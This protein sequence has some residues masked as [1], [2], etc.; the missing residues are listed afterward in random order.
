MAFGP[1]ATIKRYVIF[2]D[3]D[4]FRYRGHESIELETQE[5]LRLDAKGVKVTSVKANGS[6]VQFAQDDEGVTVRTGRFSGT[7]EVD[8][9]GEAAEKLVGIY[10]APYEGGYVISTQFES[11][12]AREMFPC[13]DNPAYKAR[14]KLS[15]RVPRDL[16]AISNMPI[17][18]VTLDGDK[19][20]VEFM[21]T[22]PMSTYLLY[23]GIGK[24]EEVVDSGGR[25]VLAAVPG[26]T[27]YGSLAL[28]AAR[29]SV[30]FY[31]RYFGIPYPLPKM[32]L[33]AVPEFAFGAMENWGA[34]TF[35]ES[36]LLAPEDADMAQRRRVAEVVAHEIAHQWFGDLVTMKWWDD[37]WLNESFATF[38][39]YKA[40]SSFAPE[41]LMWENF[42]LGE[43]DGA[44]VR[45]SLSTTHP[46]HVEV[47]SPDEIE[48]IFDDI[49]YGKGASIL[50]MVEYFLGESFRKG[51]S[52][53][54]EHHAYSNAVAQDLWT[55]IQPFTSVP[56]ADL[57]NDWITKPGYPYL[58]VT[59]EGSRVR[60]EQ[61]RFSL[62]GKLEDLTYMVPATIE[63][64][65]RRV[66]AIFSSRVHEV[67]VGEEVR[68]LKVNLDR[69][70]F[71]RVLY[72]DL[73]RLARLNQFETYGL[74]ND[75]YYFML[76]GLVSRDDYLRVVDMNFSVPDYL[77]AL[78]LSSELFNLFLVNPAVFAQR[79]IDYHRSQFAL[80][81]RRPEEQ[82]RELA[83]RVANRLAIMDR[84]FAN[85]L[86]SQ[87]GKEVDPNMRQAVYTAYAVAAG[88]LEGL[89]REH[90]RQQL[91]S[92]R[93]KV[94]VAA[95]QIRDRSALQQAIE[96]IASGKRQDMLYVLTVGLNPD[97]R[98][99][100]WG[101]LRDGGLDRLEKAFEGTA[102]VQRWL[103]G[104]LPFIG[105]GREK[106]V[107]DFFASRPDGR[108]AEVRG[109]LEILEA[110]S[111]LRQ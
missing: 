23:V 85:E 100:V 64:N 78:E 32:H 6:P 34:I 22:P 49:S 99:L 47:S 91:D 58:R 106:E 56:V 30:D 97:G 108:S 98:D 41:L 18:R 51:L 4:G 15:V 90:E 65:G 17:E 102:I 74:L 81:S 111:R 86:A 96:W 54:L 16:H 40:V 31:E 103:L 52:S 50:R 5:D 84:S 7:L 21:E 68:Q 87:F 77:P 19:K 11:V 109:G 80:Q 39:S 92:E 73:S 12:H 59:V 36:A 55:A 1:K 107:S 63:V 66:D 13:V 70:G 8:F 38:M 42:L 33:I 27:K 10:R 83:G 93:I 9:E 3:F 14:F 24:W 26:K 75:Y 61:H 2:M 71:Y 76:A 94:L 110:Y 57:M 37:L 69:A 28:W 88:D 60:L 89:R 101:W 43:T 82:H 79:A 62:S 67:D 105:L 53:Y 29:N 95:A 104:Y 72:P 44:M 20:V 35:R 48:E 25:Y 45:D 46:I